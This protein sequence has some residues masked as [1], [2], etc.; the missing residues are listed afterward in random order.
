M[1]QHSVVPPAASGIARGAALL[2]ALAAPASG[3]EQAPRIGLVL[4]GGSARG[5]AHVGV[6]E[7]LEEHAIPV[8]VVAGTSMGAC[9]GALY[10]SGHSAAE[11]SAVV[12]AIDWG[13]IFEGRPERQQEPVAWRVDD[14][15]VIVSAGLRGRRLLAPSAAV[16]D[17]RISRL[18]TEHLSAAGVRAGDDFDRLPTRFR[19][20]A[21]D[22]HSGERIVL[23]HG[24]LPR[25]VRASMSLPVLF[26]PVEI[27]GRLLVDGALSDNIPTGVARD[28]GADVVIGVDVSTPPRELNAEAG[29]LEVVGRVMDLMMSQDAEDAAAPPDVWIRPELKGVEALDFT[30]F[31]AAI[32]AG[33]AAA[34][35]A[36]PDIE[37]RLGARARGTRGRVASLDEPQGSVKSVSVVGLRGVSEKL[38]RRRLGVVEKA[39]FD[40]ASALRGLDAV[41]SSNLFSSSWLE[42]EGDGGDGLAVT[43]HVRERP[44]TRLGLGVSY[45]ESDNL[46]G[47]LRFRHG[48]LLGQGERLDLVARFDSSL[49]QFDASLGSTALG[50]AL[51][52]YRIG[53]SVTEDKPPLY[54]ASGDRAGRA[55]FRHDLAS[56][57]LLRGLGSV[58]LMDIGLAAGRSVIEPSLGTPYAARTDTVVRA[59]ARVV[60][61]SLDDRSFPSRGARADLHAEQAL[62]ALGASLDHG[63]A[64]GRVDAFVPF[65]RLALLEFHG[66]A[67][68]SHGAVPAY[69]LFRIGGPD[70]VPGRGREELSGGWAAATSVGVGVRLAR[71]TRLFVRGGAGNA[72]NEA[73]AIDLGELGAGASLGVAHDTRLGPASIELGAGSGRLRV[74]VSLG[75]R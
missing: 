70:L 28:L 21:T 74:Y 35:L 72:W 41:W 42:I 61:D 49:T 64:W 55:L 62:S 46:R 40:L 29:V 24:D 3:E 2:L 53:A 8:E 34:L 20:V 9:I 23:G 6:L 11:V 27:D 12:R 15:P 60:A 31:E 66:F 39:R 68:G 10:A 36:L 30:R 19:A 50:G 16:S 63:R 65:G 57:N 1:V 33:R 44:V 73:D 37:R 22:L 56:A 69:D 7:V 26:P 18:L 45:D 75:F 13:R 71:S 51:V 59:T 58:A 4:G 52:G 14:V 43:A 25:A 38:I 67:G 47:F 48:N 54:D 5:F 17:Y 32:A